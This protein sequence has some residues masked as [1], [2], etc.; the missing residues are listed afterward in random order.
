[1]IA[2]VRVCCESPSIRLARPKSVILGLPSGVS[3]TL[4]GFRSRWMIP[5]AWAVGHRAGRARST[6][7]AAARGGLGL[8]ADEL[9]ARLPPATNSSEK[10][11]RPSCSPT[12]WIWT[13]PG[14]WSL[15]DGLGLDVEP[16]ELVGRGVRPG[17]DHLQRDQAVEPDVPGLVDHAHAAP[18]DLLEEL[19]ADRP[20]RPGAARAVGRPRRG[21]AERPG[22]GGGGGDRGGRPKCEARSG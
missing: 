18:A 20:G 4:A 10:Y 16:G 8:A 17:Q 11:G 19:I 12:S 7:G 3:R 5:R 9:A 1:M 13:I 14:C 22:V 15:G 21:D 2:P 6:I